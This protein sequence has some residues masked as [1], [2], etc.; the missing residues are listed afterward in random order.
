MNSLWRFILRNRSSVIMLTLA[1]VVSGVLS[2]FGIQQEK[3]P[4][5][6]MPAL[7]IQVKH[8]NHSAEEIERD[9]TMPVES[10]IGNLQPY[11]AL[12]SQT[13]AGGVIIQASYEFGTDMNK[14]EQEVESAVAKLGLPEGASVAYKRIST[15]ARPVYQ[16]ALASADA[17][18]LQQQ[19]TASLLPELGRVDGVSSVDASGLSERQLVISVDEAK[20]AASGIIL[21]DISTG[22]KQSEYILPLGTLAEQNGKAVVNLEGRVADLAALQNTPLPSKTTPGLRLRDIATITETE[23][24]ANIARYNGQP[25]VLLDVYKTQDSNTAEV[26][27]QVKEQLEAFHSTV[28]FESNT[29]VDQG[30]DVTESVQS[31]LHEGAFGALFTIVVIL[32]FLRNIRATLIAVISLPLSIMGTIIVLD[33]MGYSLNIMTMGGMA[34]AVGRIVDDSI[35]VI[36]NIFRWLRK[37]PDKS[38]TEILVHAVKEVAGAV[39]ASTVATVVVFV[40]LAFVKGIVGE[41]F[42]PF[43]LAVVVS[44]L[45]SLLIAFV[46]IPVLAALL[47]K[48]LPEHSESTRLSKG[49][50]RLLQQAVAHKAMVLLVALAMLAGSVFFAS[51]ISKSFLPSEASQALKIRL[52]LPVTASLEQTDA[53]ARIVE[54]QLTKMEQVE[55][56]QAFVGS[57]GNVQRLQQ[58]K[59][60]DYTA[61]LQVGLSS[62]SEMQSIREELEQSLPAL[63]QT[64]Y[65]AA[66]VTID[67]L[68]KDGPPSGSNV[69]VILSGESMTDLLAASAQAY[70][71]MEQKSDL[72]NQSTS[73]AQLQNEYTLTLKDTAR[74]KG[75]SPGLIYQQVK[76]RLQPV[77]IGIL[78][79]EDQ[80]YQTTLRYNQ[81]VAGAEALMG[82]K[83]ATASGPALLGDLAEAEVIEVPATI[84]HQNGK[85]AVKLTAMSSGEEIGTVTKELKGDMAALSLPDGV[86]WEVGGGQ[87]L[88]QDGFKDLGTAMLLAVVL[89]FIVLFITFGGCITPVV[90]LSSLLF[91]PFGSLGA[92]YLAGESLSMSGM[93][94]MLMLIGI[95]VTNAVVMLERIETNRRSGMAITEAVMEACVV[96]VRP[97]VMTALATVC[98]LIPLALSQS[99]SGVIS[100]GLAISVIGGLSTSTLL[101]LVFIPVVYSLLGK[102]RRL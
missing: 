18:G 7:V 82:I 90:I 5:V 55:Y 70:D 37:E 19:I 6:E 35:V 34:V 68:V 2:A 9:I 99:G 61:E 49:Y 32:L 78:N 56:V 67:E 8:L 98:A 85:L 39:T 12:T 92:L 14:L 25:A 74:Q 11:D 53:M 45:L 13:S 24:A 73:A 29:I 102:W 66:S 10:T 33:S 86:S 83:V 58:N 26:V 87:K 31:L 100:K 59:T 64:G 62:E 52:D 79:L 57:S 30:A 69:E 22:L 77:S 16:V 1:L 44:I 93:I 72:K 46:L 43:S 17:A 36:E 89:V 88:M 4:N 84:Q 65:P 81:D 20:A 48:K 27:D 51:S 63:V 54:E 71:M 75:V 96:R 21:S 28:S 38:R 15:D 94:G 91:V 80:H 47:F 23:L 97:I 40:P 50:T 76:D 41:F 42:R 60:G 95:V 101:T 3:Y